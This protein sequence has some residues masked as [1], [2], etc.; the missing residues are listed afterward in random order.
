MVVAYRSSKTVDASVN[1]TPCFARFSRSLRGSHANFTAA[2]YNAAPLRE[3]SAGV[4][5]TYVRLSCGRRQRPEAPRLGRTPPAAYLHGWE[6]RRRRGCAPRSRCGVAERLPRD[7]VRAPTKRIATAAT[8][9]MVAERARAG[10]PLLTLRR[11][12]G[13]R[14]QRG[15]VFGRRLPTR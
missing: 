7:G 2:K 6:Q 12:E 4:Q 10:G 14:E 5:A 13:E 1:A 9:L 3:R 8:S 15:V 11:C